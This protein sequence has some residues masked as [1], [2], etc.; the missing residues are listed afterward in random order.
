MSFEDRIKSLLWGDRSLEDQATEDLALKRLYQYVGTDFVEE[1]SFEFDSNLFL[2]FYRLAKLENYRGINDPDEPLIWREMQL[3]RN[4]TGQKIPRERA[5][6]YDG[7][8]QGQTGN[9]GHHPTLNTL[10]RIVENYK[11]SWSLFLIEENKDPERL[12]SDLEDRVKSIHVPTYE[13]VLKVKDLLEFTEEMFNL[14]LELAVS[15]YA[16][17]KLE[18][19]NLAWSSLSKSKELL[20]FYV[21]ARLKAEKDAGF[22]YIGSRKGPHKTKRKEEFVKASLIKKMIELFDKGELPRWKGRK[23]LEFE[24]PNLL[25]PYALSLNGVLDQV[26]NNIGDK[27]L[28]S[29][30][31]LYLKIGSWLRADGDFKA[32]LEMIVDSYSKDEVVGTSKQSKAYVCLQKEWFK[33]HK[34]LI[35]SNLMA[36][37]GT[38]LSCNSDECPVKVNSVEAKDNLLKILSDPLYSG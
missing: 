29:N 28:Q 19:H 21:G 1:H 3:K 20:G 12:V 34:R 35:E 25:L 24:L 32:A 30:E 7:E 2:V 14:A 27:E 38:F 36:L 10:K 31:T 11:G 22:N 9:L 4:A 8:Y 23:S 6:V 15:A 33:D 18:A 5:N 37:N 26:Y 16:A 17:Y 13:R